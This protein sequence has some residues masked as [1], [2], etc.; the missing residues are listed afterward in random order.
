MEENQER[1]KNRIFTKKR[2]AL[3]ALAVLVL[4]AGSGI[5][6]YC[7]GCLNSWMRPIAGTVPYP[8]VIVEGKNVI[9]TKELISNTDAMKKFYEEN[10]LS[11]VGMRVDFSTEDGKMRLRIKEKDVLNKLVENELIKS[12]A[13]KRGIS[14]SQKEAGEEIASKAK[15]SG[16][17]NNLAANLRRLYGWELEDFQDKVVIPQ[18]YMEKMMRRHREEIAGKNKL[19]KI[20][21]AKKL[22]DEDGDFSEIA[23]KYSEGE[24][25]EQGGNLGWLKEK[26]MAPAVAE[27]IAGM[28]K[29]TYSDIIKSSLGNHIVYLEDTRE[30]NGEKEVKIKQVFTREGN[31]LSWLNE[32][33][34]S[35]SVR[36]LLHEYK[37]DKEEAKIKFSDPGL[38]KKEEQIRMKSEGDPSVN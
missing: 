35:S 3:L 5:A 21:E 10:D 28:E 2:L 19:K 31:F 17:L 8:A 6:L 20:N 22:L 7:F 12:A 30:K 16:N 38:E 27:K 25:A 26:H 34:A 32:L 37:W 11:E 23:K 15:K 1:K 18:M 4:L 14:V 33:K 36:V 24:A 9:T 29:E 13:E